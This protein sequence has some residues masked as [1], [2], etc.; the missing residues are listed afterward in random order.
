MKLSDIVSVEEECMRARFS[1]SHLLTLSNGSG[2][3]FERQHTSQRWIYKLKMLWEPVFF[4]YHSYFPIAS[5]MKTQ[6]EQLSKKYNNVV[7]I[8][9]NI[10][11]DERLSSLV[12]KH[13]LVIRLVFDHEFPK[14]QMNCSRIRLDNLSIWFLAVT[15]VGILFIETF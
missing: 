7:P 6:L 10:T 12:K 15:Q 11:E 13:N 1:W 5:I 3:G 8:I 14:V 9:M 4:I 2:S